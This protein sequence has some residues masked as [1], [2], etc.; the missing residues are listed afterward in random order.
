MIDDTNSPSWKL[1]ENPFYITPSHHHHHRHH[2]HQTSHKSS[3]NTNNNNQLQFYCLKFSSSSSSD[4]F[5]TKR[6]MDSELDLARSQIVE[7]KTQLRYERKA[8]KKL[9]SLTKRLAKELDEERKQREAMEGLCQE[10][11]REI[12]SHEAQMDLMKK[13]IEDER[14]MLRFGFILLFLF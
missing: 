13:E 14:K 1:Y 6:R 11:A 9:E 3:I 7:L 12:S 10:L 5:P 4:L 8:R 2:R